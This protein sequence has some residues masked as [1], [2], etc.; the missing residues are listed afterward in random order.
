LFAKVEWREGPRPF[1]R[2]GEGR[3]LPEELVTKICVRVKV[4]WYES[5]EREL[6]ANIWR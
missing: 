6:G 2:K 1:V 5:K 4:E 3:R